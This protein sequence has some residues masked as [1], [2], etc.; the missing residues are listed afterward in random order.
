MRDSLRFLLEFVKRPKNTGAIAPS[1]EMLAGAIV[2]EIGLEEADLAM[3]FGPGSGAF[4]G[5]ILRKLPSDAEFLA[6]E[7]NERM[8][9]M[10]R[11]RHPDATIVDDSIARAPSILRQRGYPPESVDS[12]VSGLPWASFDDQLQN[13]LLEATLEILKPG[14][15]FATFAY[16]HGLVL[17]TGRRFRQKLDTRFGGVETS[18]IVWRNLPPAFIYRC[19]KSGR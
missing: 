9:R 2:E 19:T 5:E 10:F 12:I 1:S 8:L 7:N 11:R 16:I 4:T 14:G 17:P 13:E 6:I 18:E 3:E 15:M